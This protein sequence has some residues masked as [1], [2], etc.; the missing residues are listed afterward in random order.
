M[1]IS[2]RLTAAAIAL[3]LFAAAP[4]FAQEA[5]KGPRAI[6]VDP[7]RFG[8]RQPDAAFGAFQ[9]GLYI[10]AFNLAR[11]R[12]EA[13]DPAAQTLIAEIYSRGLGIAR[14]AGKA[15]HWY[16]K[17]AE[18]G[19][20]EAQFQYGL[21][22][23]DGTI[24]AA[25][26]EEALRYLRL[27]A[28]QGHAL[29]QFNFA[30]LTLKLRPGAEGMKLAADYYEKAASGGLPDAEY[31]MAQV[32]AAGVGGRSR[33]LREARRWLEEAARKNFDTAQLDLATW[34]IE[35]RGGKR[36]LEAGFNWMRIA[37][38]GG[39]V[40]AQNRLA[41]LYRGGIGT[42]G[43]PIT[44]AAWSIIARRAGLND[45]EMNLFLDGLTGEQQQKAIEL[46]NRLR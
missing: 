1:M 9:R 33:D 40:A 29:A 25:S 43:D 17:A 23:I 3:L 11:P 7:A 30:Q 45:R 14:D 41:K 31:A 12:A 18:Q 5:D 8:S 35:G 20:A 42:E 32:Y 46:A 19:V 13:G 27:A 22:L 37:A 39:N 15:V 4:V 26:N 38:S 24:V 16:A 21:A 28:D 10:T 2:I 36:D 6:S 44:A 34:L